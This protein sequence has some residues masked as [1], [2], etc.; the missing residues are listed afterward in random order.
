M[1]N[2]ED[3]A[4]ETGFVK[5]ESLINGSSFLELLLLNS[6]K[7]ALLSLEDLACEFESLYGQTI[8]KQ[9][10]DERF[11]QQAVL[12]LN[13]IMVQLLSQQL[14]MKTNPEKEYHFTACRLKDSTRFGLPDSYSTVY[15]GHGGATNTQSMISIQYEF[16]LLTG[17]HLGLQ[18]TS[19]CRNDQ[20]DSNESVGSIKE[21]ELLIRDLGYT[22]STYLS[23]VVEKNAFFLNRLPTQ[24]NVYEANDN[25]KQ[26]DFKKIYKKLNRYNLPYIEINVFIGKK[27]QI[28]CRLVVSK[29]EVKAAQRRLK[30]TTKNTKS[31]GHKVSK[32]TK[33]KSKLNMY[34][35]NA[36]MNMIATKDIYHIYSLR[37]QI[38]LIFKAWKSICN[39]N[40]IKK[41]KI[42]RFECILLSGLIWVL[43]N[44][45]IFQIANLWLTQETETK[46]MSIWKYYRFVSNNQIKVCSVLYGK[47]HLDEWLIHVLNMA[48]SKLILETKKGREPHIQRINRL[49]KN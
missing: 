41:V 44:W 24:M 25:N 45:K 27:A 26:I 7:G 9:G 29:C 11:N 47:E 23:K 30:K 33:V 36:P 8:T 5:R 13:N 35:T 48:E 22:T 16:D 40:K 17:D 18:L 37:W 2:I 21:G 28:P 31:T 38:E 10:I 4:K 39:I 6:T 20:K 46:T 19:G 49:K 32:E 43:A 34:I 1:V 14:N 15:K 3:Q 42:H 12:F